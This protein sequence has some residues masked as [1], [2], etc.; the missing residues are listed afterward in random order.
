M[1]T[2]LQR[3]YALV[4]EC[5]MLYHRLFTRTPLILD[6]AS[7]LIEAIENRLSSVV[8]VT[9]KID[10]VSRQLENKERVR[11]FVEENKNEYAER[12]MTLLFFFGRYRYR[13][14]TGDLWLGCTNCEV[15]Q[16]PGAI[17]ISGWQQKSMRKMEQVTLILTYQEE[18]NV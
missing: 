18:A 10:A 8:F 9:E 13:F 12:A 16:Y 17:E 5:K 7:F 4:E 2:E 6:T 3:Y 1:N 15:L 14:T 11:L